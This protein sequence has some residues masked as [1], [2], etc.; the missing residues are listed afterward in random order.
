SAISGRLRPSA[1]EMKTLQDSTRGSRPWAR[2]VRKARVARE[3]FLPR[4]QTEKT[5][6]RAGTAPR[7]PPWGA[8]ARR[9]VRTTW[10]RR[11]GRRGAG[12]RGGGRRGARRSG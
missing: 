12:R 5:T 7:P 3:S 1:A 11:S 4:A 10:W 2:M 6:L 9:A 8:A